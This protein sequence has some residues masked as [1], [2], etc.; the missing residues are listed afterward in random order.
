MKIRMGFVTNSSSSSF[1][2]SKK[3][4]TKDQLEAIKIHEN[5]AKALGMW[6][7]YAHPWEIEENKNFISGYTSMDNFSMYNFLEEIGIPQKYVKWSEYQFDI[8]DYDYV[9]EEEQKSQKEN[10]W[11]N[12]LHDLLQQ[13]KS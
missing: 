2:I 12:A 13:E 3:R 4:I 1:I 8:D 5:L 9:L 7:E 6:G 10:L 11:V